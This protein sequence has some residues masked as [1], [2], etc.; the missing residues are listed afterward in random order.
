MQSTKEESSI[1]SIC[2]ELVS[3]SVPAGKDAETSTA[4][5][6]KQLIYADHHQRQKGRPA[7]RQAGSA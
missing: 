6:N 7:C 4:Q 1:K 5:E 3:V 2:A